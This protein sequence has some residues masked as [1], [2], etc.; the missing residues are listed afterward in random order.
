MVLTLLYTM[1]SR[2]ARGN[3]GEPQ[4]SVFRERGLSAAGGPYCSASSP[5]KSP[6]STPVIRVGRTRL[7]SAAASPR[8]ATA[9]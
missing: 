5:S 8:T 6:S 1:N 4:K 3:F 7:W 2:I 9:M